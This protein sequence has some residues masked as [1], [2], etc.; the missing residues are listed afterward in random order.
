[1]QD[2]ARIQEFMLKRERCIG[3]G[4]Q[5]GP[6]QRPVGEGGGTKK[7]TCEVP[8]KLLGIKICERKTECIL[9]VICSVCDR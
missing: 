5:A 4:S 3:E 1:M 9:S 6:G 8:R 7:G 2:Q